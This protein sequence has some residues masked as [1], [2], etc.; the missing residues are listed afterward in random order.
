[1][2]LGDTYTEYYGLFTPKTTY[3]NEINPST[4]LEFGASLLR[5]LHSQIPAQLK[6]GV[7]YN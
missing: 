4:S 5:T 1:M 6:Y 3:N 2:I 7:Y